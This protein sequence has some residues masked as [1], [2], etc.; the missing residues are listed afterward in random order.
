M[1]ACIGDR[2]ALAIPYDGLLRY[3][4]SSAFNDAWYNRDRRRLTV[5]WKSILHCTWISID[6]RISKQYK[7]VLVALATRNTVTRS[8]SYCIACRRS[9]RKYRCTRLVYR[10]PEILLIRRYQTIQRWYYIPDMAL[11]IPSDVDQ[12]DTVL[13]V[14][15]YVVLVFSDSGNCLIAPDTGQYWY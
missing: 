1:L 9:Y 14:L 13:G 8:S 7:K 5:S 4:T 12:Y 6:T 11:A 2:I 3:G 15:L 10:I